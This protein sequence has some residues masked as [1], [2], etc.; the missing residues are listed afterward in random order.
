MDKLK[1][2]LSGQDDT[3]DLNVLQVVAFDSLQPAS[4]TE[5]ELGCNR[6]VC[7]KYTVLWFRFESES[8]PLL[9]ILFPACLPDCHSQKLKNLPIY[10]Y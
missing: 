1:K 8:R 7:L 3:D 2:V 10:E 6:C 4:S 9:F 5:L